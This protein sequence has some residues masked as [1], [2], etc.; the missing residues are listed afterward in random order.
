MY[1]FFWEIHIMIKG[2]LVAINR[3]QIVVYRCIDDEIV[4]ERRYFR[5]WISPL[6]EARFNL[7][8]RLHCNDQYTGFMKSY[9]SRNFVDNTVFQAYL[10]RAA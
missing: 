10:N 2:W 5:K 3:D 8:V 1:G 7:F 9:F 6:S 4:S